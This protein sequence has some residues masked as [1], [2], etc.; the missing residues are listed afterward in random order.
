MGLR[1]HNANTEVMS[2]SDLRNVAELA[3]QGPSVLTPGPGL[4]EN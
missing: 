2:L 3:E 1:G 4:M